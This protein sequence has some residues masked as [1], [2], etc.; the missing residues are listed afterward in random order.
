[1]SPPSP[2]ADQSSRRLSEERRSALLL[3]AIAGLLLG[4]L[5]W[6]IRAPSF[7]QSVIDHDESTYIVIGE[8]IWRGELLYTDVWDTKPA[9]IFLIFGAAL[10]LFGGSVYTIRVLA[11]LA[12]TLTA[13]ALTFAKRR[14]GM[15]WLEG[16]TSGALCVLMCSAQTYGLP[17]HIELFFIPGVAIALWMLSGQGS[18]GVMRTTVAGLALGL[19][20]IVKYVALFDAIA[21]TL[22]L[23]LYPCYRALRDGTERASH[24]RRLLIFAVVFALPFALL[25]LAFTLTGNFQAFYEATYVIPGRYVNMGSDAARWRLWVELHRVYPYITSALYLSLLLG[26]L[27]WLKTR[28]GG[29]ELSLAT[30]WVLCAWASVL[31]PGKPFTHYLLQLALP[32]SFYAPRA[33]SLIPLKALSRACLSVTLISIF[34][35]GDQRAE[36]Y[37]RVYRH[38]PD[39]PREAAAYL[40]G[41]LEPQDLI[42]TANFDHILYHLLQRRSPTK[43][44]HRS[45]LTNPKHLKTLAL[46]PQREIAHILSQRPRFILTVGRYRH[47]ALN[48]ALRRDYQRV[49]TLRRRHFIYERRPIKEIKRE[50]EGTMPSQR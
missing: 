17:A 50:A 33:L 28:R 27:R 3:G 22:P 43:Y 46:D 14:L 4:G 30:L 42:Y 40:R 39:V 37:Q 29:L 10:K 13:I 36:T 6:W 1:M 32:I 38:R 47:R 11:T 21:L 9:G 15:S 5:A 45:L 34:I 8:A 7:M 18:P 41:R 49:K 44:V 31:T 26:I 19:A 12:I 48:E 25:H 16:I 35:Y 23:L 20:F 24:M 2:S